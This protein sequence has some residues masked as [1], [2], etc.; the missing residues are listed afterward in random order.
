MRTLTVIAITLLSWARSADAQS[1]IIS[2]KHDVTRAPIGGA[3]VSLIAFGGTVIAA[4]FTNDSG[5]VT[6]RSPA[7]GSY[8]IL[9]RRVGYRPAH[10][11]ATVL[12]DRITSI[13]LRLTNGPQ[14][15]LIPVIVTSSSA[16]GSYDDDRSVS[17]TL[18]EQ[19]RTALEANRLVE[20]EG[21]VR[22][23]IQKYERDLDRRFTERSKLVETKEVATRQ[24]FS[25]AP[26]G[27]LET[28]GYV[29][30]DSVSAIYYAPDAKTLLSEEF[31]HSHCFSVQ[32]GERALK[33][34][35]G[36]AFAPK[37]GVVR[38]DIT[39]VLWV[40]RKSSALDHLAYSYV[41]VP[42]AVCL[43]GIGGQ[44]HFAP[45]ASGAWI[46]PRWYIRTPRLGRITRYID[47]YSR[48]QVVDTLLGF[49]ETGA[50]ARILR[51]GER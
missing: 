29:T 12:A 17:Y 10:S 7:P 6:L 33:H 50:S 46:I 39:G 25:A 34:L 4:R 5:I 44:I 24:P 1:L 40:D 42:S 28:T 45:L 36:L 47:S 23:E 2:V 21:L 51:D 8:R 9:A 49:R 43:E 38:P 27:V 11:S 37:S 13:E 31:A 14:F 16:C 32:P 20:S 41:N 3:M 19:I 15:S 26:A 48:S 22:M 35:I 30:P 18:W